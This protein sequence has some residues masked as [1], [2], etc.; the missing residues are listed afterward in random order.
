MY[1]WLAEQAREIDLAASVAGVRDEDHPRSR[2]R[3]DEELY[4][5]Q[6]GWDLAEE[7]VWAAIA[8]APDD[9]GDEPEGG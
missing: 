1:A 9:P 6:D 5:P 4:A 3:L 8:A 2:Q 7:R